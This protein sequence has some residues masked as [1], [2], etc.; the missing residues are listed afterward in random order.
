MDFKL[1]K[2]VALFY[3]IMLGD[4]C[5][6]LVKGKKKYI[7]ITGSSIDDVPFFEEILSPILK[8][9]RG[10]ET[11]I[12]FRKNCNAIDF[13]FADHKLFDYIHSLGFPIGKKGPKISI[14][15][16]FYDNNL[17]KYV[18]QGFFATD[19][20]IVLTKNPNKFYPRIEAHAI[21]K[22]LIIQTHNY[23]VKEGMKG[24]FYE[25]KR[26]KKEFR[27]KTQQQKYRFQFNGK[28]N[29]ILFNNIIGFVN[30]KQKKKFNNFI[31]YSNKY[32]DNRSRLQFKKPKAKKENLNTIFIKEMTPGRFELPISSS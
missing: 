26:N 15:Q 6:S 14:P 3:G 5:L 20:S 27:W 23:L 22:E 31:E 16:I 12:K 21:A 8:K 24:H 18:T 2:D 32:G 25:C 11:K 30:P 17:I 9:L 13:N 4:G 7:S 28:E 1:N 19:G 29:L 10:K